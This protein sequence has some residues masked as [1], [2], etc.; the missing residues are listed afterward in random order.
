MPVME[1]LGWWDCVAGGRMKNSLSCVGSVNSEMPIRHAKTEKL[2]YKHSFEVESRAKEMGFRVI[3]F[4]DTIR[5][6]NWA[7]V[8]MKRI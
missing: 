6:W 1:P 5:L 2:G 8:L 3:K 4:N 7:G